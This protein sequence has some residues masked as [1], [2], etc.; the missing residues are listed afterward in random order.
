MFP[1]VSPWF[2]H[3]EITLSNHSTYAKQTIYFYY[4]VNQYVLASLRCLYTH[5]HILAVNQFQFPKH[6]CDWDHERAQT[7][8]H[9]FKVGNLGNLGGMQTVTIKYTGT[10]R[11]RRNKD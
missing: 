4:I 9:Y 8:L 7:G 10:H 6:S 3:P 1:T 5:A 11:P 2:Y